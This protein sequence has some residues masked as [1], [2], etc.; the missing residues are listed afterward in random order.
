MS[1]RRHS[2]IGIQETNNKPEASS[3]EPI[4]EPPKCKHE[5]LLMKS[6]SQEASQ[7]LGKKQRG[8][9]MTALKNPRVSFSSMKEKFELNEENLQ[10]MSEENEKTDLN[11]SD[12]E[13]EESKSKEKQRKRD[14]QSEILTEGH[15]AHFWRGLALMA[16][17]GV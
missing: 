13:S 9:F 5:S 10:A 2:S 15:M 7:S 11:E 3:S 1:Q 8:S 6:R 16:P 12:T 14:R 4:Q 17:G